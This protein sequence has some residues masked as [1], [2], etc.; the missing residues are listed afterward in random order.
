[1]MS[2]KTAES[3]YDN[4]IR[5]LLRL[6]IS[7]D[8]VHTVDPHRIQVKSKDIE[9]ACADAH[10][11][12]SWGRVQGKTVAGW[13]ADEITRHPRNFV[14]MAQSRCRYEGRIWPKFW[15]CN[16]EHPEHFILND[17][18]KNEKIDLLSWHFTLED[19]PALTQ[20]YK[21]ELR[22]S[23]S[24]VFYQ[25]YIEGKWVLAEG[26]VYPDFD[27]ELHVKEFTLVDSWRRIRGIDFGYTNP[28]VCLWGAI[29]EDGRLYIYD[30]HYRAK[31][32]IAD[33][34]AAIGKREGNFNFTVSDH[35]AQERAELGF[36]TRA[37][38][39]EVQLGI[40]K[41]TS[42]LLI[43]GDSRPRLFIHPRCVNLIR[44]FGM[45]RW[46][47]IKEG[48]NEKEEPIKENDHAMD[49][50]RYMVMELDNRKV[51]LYG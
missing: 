49:A 51:Y 26:I 24:G 47:D 45:Y 1:M 32:L 19:N 37:A 21:D 4:V 34:V 41:V 29:D 14:Q 6:D 48:K 9:I 33:H 40:Q 8:M 5:D 16:P 2:G 3:L 43:A 22:N 42:R 39:K 35:D 46:N 20:E 38:Q 44:E 23:Y 18:L 30:E 13:L 12:K 15:T 36:A 7:G 25:R 27:Q 11:E 31:T 10:N 17:Y 50:L 28:F